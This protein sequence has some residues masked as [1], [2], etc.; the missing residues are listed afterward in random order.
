VIL[1]DC[2]VQTREYDREEAQALA[3]REIPEGLERVRIVHIGDF[4]RSAC[5]GTHLRTTGELGLLHISGWEQRGEHTRVAFLC[6]WRALDDYFSKDRICQQVANDLSVAVGELPEAIA[7]LEEAENAA[8]R[9]ARDLRSRLLDLELPHL[10]HEAEPVDGISVLARLLADHDGENMRHVA[11]NLVEAQEGIVVLLA[12][13]EPGPQICFACSNDVDVDMP[14]LLRDA[15]AP[16][17]GRGGGEPHLAQG[18]GMAADDV[19]DVLAD[20][21]EELVSRL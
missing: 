19:P 2:P 15:A 5:G 7:R 13:T 9:E 1:T 21:K 12:V 20:A 17:G 3:R 11:R 8:R 14:R 6:G 18:G 10:L 16:Y 4:D